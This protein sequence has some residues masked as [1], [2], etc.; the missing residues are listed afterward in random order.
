MAPTAKLPLLPTTVVG[1]YSV[2]DWYPV[3]QERVEQGA[4]PPSAFGDAKEI[5]ALGAIKDQET[6]GIDLISDGELFRRDNNRFG[7]PNAMINYFAAKV[8]GFSGELRDRSGITPLDPSASLPA[9][10][11]TGRLRPAPLGLVEEM[12]FL[13]R[14]SSRP[15]KIAMTGAHMFA[16]IVWDE[17]YG[18]PE[19][20]AMEMA[21]VIN[22]ELRRL[23]RAGCDVI[24]LD[25]PILWFRPDA[26]AWGIKAINACFQGVKRAKRALHVCQGNYNPDPAAHRGLRIFPSEFKAILPVMQGAQVDVI[27]MAFTALKE[28]DIS[29]LKDFPKDKVL[30]VGTIDVQNHRVETPAQVARTIRRVLKYVP[31]RRLFVCPDCGLNH[32]PRPVAFGKLQVM[33]RGA[34]LVRRALSGKRP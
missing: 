21:K 20:L 11:V 7:P 2:P 5:A 9:P 17:Q 24:Q 34:R 31:A 23:D 12:R 25:E 22:A 3:L 15:V 30:G 8:P 13:R 19:T 18:S 33:V 14:Y 26:Q 6:A 28:K 1:S 4:M 16:S 29:A 27:L 10:V 32:L